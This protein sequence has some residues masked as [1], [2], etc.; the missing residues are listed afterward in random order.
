MILIDKNADGDM[1]KSNIKLDLAQLIALCK[2]TDVLIERAK[3]LQEKLAF[4]YDAADHFRE[5]CSYL[6]PMKKDQAI[7]IE[8]IVINFC[9]F[10]GEK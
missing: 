4:D 9:E 3:A 6:K 8:G 10:K 7:I 5:L 2:A 1:K